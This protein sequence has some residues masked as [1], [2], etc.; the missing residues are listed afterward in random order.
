MGSMF[1]TLFMTNSNHDMVVR[2]AGIFGVVAL[3]LLMIQLLRA[4]HVVFFRFGLFCL[5]VFLV[6]YY[7]YETNIYIEALP[8]I[9]KITFISFLS[10]FALLDVAI[11]KRA[12]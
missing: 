7:I 9:Q 10:W 1:I 2:L 8:V 6:N 5:L 11:Y 4:A 3:V 12:D